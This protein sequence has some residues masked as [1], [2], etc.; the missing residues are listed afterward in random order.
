[1]WTEREERNYQ[2]ITKTPNPESHRVDLCQF[3]KSFPL[4]SAS[5]NMTSLLFHFCT[6]SPD[7]FNNLPFQGAMGREEIAFKQC[8]IQ[9][10]GNG[11]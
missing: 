11:F 3:F 2:T 10:N 7:Y 5:S 6:S 8:R 9:A 4:C 1:M